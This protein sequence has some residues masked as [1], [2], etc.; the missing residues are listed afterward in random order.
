MDADGKVNGEYLTF[1]PTGQQAIPAFTNAQRLGVGAPVLDMI[2]VIIQVSKQT[3]TAKR[4]PE[5]RE[6]E[7]KTNPK[8]GKTF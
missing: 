3:E 7:K 1:D 8:T 5:R 4:V 6:P 2:R